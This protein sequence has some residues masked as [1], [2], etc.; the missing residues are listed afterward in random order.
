[1]SSS[2]SSFRSFVE[3]VRICSLSHFACRVRSI[4][5]KSGILNASASAA[6]VCVLLQASHASQFIGILSPFIGTVFPRLRAKKGAKAPI[7]NRPTDTRFHLVLRSSRPRTGCSPIQTVPSCPVSGHPWWR[8]G[9]IQ[10]RTGRASSTSHAPPNDT[11][12]IELSCSSGD[13]RHPGPVV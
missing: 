3:T 13:S 9:R 4:P 12:S 11:A 6:S 1:M 5:E 7:I 10:W 8:P 2:Y